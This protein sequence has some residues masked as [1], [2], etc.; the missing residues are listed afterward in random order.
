MNSG[1]ERNYRQDV[2][3]SFTAVGI[4]AT[5]LDFPERHYEEESI[6]RADVLTNDDALGRALDQ[7]QGAGYID[8]VDGRWVVI[9]A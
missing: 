6:L 3:L 2:R 4:L 5:M 9:P 1:P 8:R 7:L